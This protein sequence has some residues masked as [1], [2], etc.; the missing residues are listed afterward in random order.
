[1]IV[2]LRETTPAEF[3]SFLER[4]GD[5]EEC[6]LSNLDAGVRVTADGLPRP[7]AGE[8]VL[9]R[10]LAAKAQLWHSDSKQREL[11]GSLACLLTDHM[12]RGTVVG[13]E[14]KEHGALWTGSDP[15]RRGGIRTVA[16]ACRLA[17]IESV[18]FRRVLGIAS[19][20]F[21]YRGY[22]LEAISVEAAT[23]GFRPRLLGF[24]PRTRRFARELESAIGS[25]GSAGNGE[26][27]APPS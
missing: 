20:R 21:R 25:L 10:W 22:Q 11:E 1:M 15:A 13:G 17:E 18:E 7:A 14:A 2:P 23:T 24:R 27:D 12:L 5:E 19:T 9:S 6:T 8:S 26:L 3:C 16:F 4:V